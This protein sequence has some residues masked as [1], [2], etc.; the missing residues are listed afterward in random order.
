M[1]TRAPYG[2]VAG[3]PL[4]GTDPAGLDLWDDVSS[5]AGEI[6]SHPGAALDDAWHGFANFSAGI[7][8]FALSTIP[9][10]GWHIGAPYCGAGLGA[11]SEIGYWT[12]AVE[13]ALA[14]GGGIGAADDGLTVAG[15]QATL[16]GAERLTQAG[17]DEAAV[18][19][20]KAGQVLQQADGATV[21]LNEVSAG[22]YDFIVEGENGVITAHRNWSEKAIERIARNYGWQG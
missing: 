22:R 5:A 6:I 1:D 20:T 17:F 7:G 14:G 16:H 9:L 11:S 8:N 13:A 18:A 2:Y 12:G 4:S 19:A 10:A 21:Y 3:N 15:E